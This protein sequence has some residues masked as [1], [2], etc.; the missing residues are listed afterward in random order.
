M[1]RVPPV[2]HGGILASSGEKRTARKN[3]KPVVT[4]VNPVL[5]PTSTP[6]ALSMYAVTADNPK[7]DA[8]IAAAPSTEN[9]ILDLGKFPSESIMS[10][11]FAKP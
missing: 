10:K 6:E 3:R 9:A 8:T 5:P 2:A 1:T 11:D 4:A 7:Q